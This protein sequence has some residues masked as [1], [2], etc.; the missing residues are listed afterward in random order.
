MGGLGRMDQN[1][2][3]CLVTLWSKKWWMS[4]FMFIPDGTVQNDWLLYQSSSSHNN[5]PFGSVSVHRGIVNIY[6]MKHSSRQRC[7]VFSSADVTLFRGNSNEWKVPSEVRFNG[8]KHY[9]LG[10]PT[11]CRCSYCGRRSNYFMLKMWYWTWHWLFWKLHEPV[12]Q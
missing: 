4:F 12:N 9:P 5:E 2:S 11:Q 3:Y 1:I 6:Q 10:N 8:T 7:H